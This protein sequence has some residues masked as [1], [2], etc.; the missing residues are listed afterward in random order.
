MDGGS[1]C[2][3]LLR[4]DQFIYLHKKFIPCS[5]ANGIKSGFHGVGVA[6]AELAPDLHV[7]LAPCYYSTTDD[8]STLSPGA[9]KRYSGCEK[10]N[11][12]SVG[13]LDYSKIVIKHFKAPMQTKVG[14]NSFFTIK[15]PKFIYRSGHYPAIS[16]QEESEEADIEKSKSTTSKPK[17]K[18]K[19]PQLPN[20]SSRGR[21][22][23]RN[24]VLNVESFQGKE[25]PDQCIVIPQTNALKI[26]DKQKTL[27][28]TYLHRK[29]GCQS[30]QAIAE[31][32]KWGI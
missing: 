20:I 30:M 6:V 31:T 9:L 15:P 23:K 1:N 12:E 5:L 4:E 17:L 32:A 21:I 29:F 19:S 2:H 28:A 8:V 16:Q 10:A 14:R 18:E 3:I 26:K 24:K 13:G 27:L 22:R 11:L 25:Y 7:L